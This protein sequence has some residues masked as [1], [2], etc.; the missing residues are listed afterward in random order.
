[1]SLLQ[2]KRHG[3]KS[4]EDPVEESEVTEELEDG[5]IADAK[6]QATS[7]ATTKAVTVLLWGALLAG[8]AALG[9]IGYSW[10]QGGDPVPVQAEQVV[11]QS[12]ERAIAGEF[13]GRV[14]TAWLTATREESSELAA[15]VAEA[16]A[17]P[18]QAEPLEVEQVSVAGIEPAGA[19][20][21][22]VTVAA[23]VTDSEGQAQRRY[24]QVPVM[25]AGDAVTALALPSV[26]APPMVAAPPSSVYRHAVPSSSSINT[27]VAGFLSAYV[28]G[29]G[30]LSRYLTPDVEDI[31]A[32][33]PVPFTE[34][35]VVGLRSTT[36]VDADATPADGDELRVLVVVTGTVSQDQSLTGTYALSL[37]ARASRWEISA[38]DPAPASSITQTPGTED[39]LPGQLSPTGEVP[40]AT[41]GGTQSPDSP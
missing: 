16:D 22:S 34:V 3:R 35:S 14:A 23:T 9:V 12:G 15:L 32:V 20:V 2:L 17:A 25:V 1:M 38:I 24:L 31:N 19:G 26:V 21:W 6:T 5:L 4:A 7:A 36:S 37:T 10:M 33:S 28:A 40:T 11:D 13:A 30:D 8:P 41:S 27:T 29:S 18:L 39:S